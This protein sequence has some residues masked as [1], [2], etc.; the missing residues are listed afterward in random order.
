MYQLSSSSDIFILLAYRGALWFL[1]LFAAMANVS[2]PFH[3]Y[4]QY[5]EVYEVF[6]LVKNSSIIVICSFVSMRA[7]HKLVCTLIP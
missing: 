4:M 1:H 7:F 2:I 6:K 3:E 5:L